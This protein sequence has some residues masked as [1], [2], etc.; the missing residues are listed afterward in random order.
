M[1]IPRQPAKPLSDFERKVHEAVCGIPPG[2]AATYAV[3]AKACGCG[4]ARAVGQALRKNPLAPQVPCHRVVQS[5]GSIG[6]FFGKT[7]EEA[8]ARKRRL[9][10]Q[11][12]VKFDARGRVLVRFLKQM[13]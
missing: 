3:V 4:S 9:L 5:N 6:G 10:E 2:F 1:D 11:E 13:L 7:S 12:G 8:M